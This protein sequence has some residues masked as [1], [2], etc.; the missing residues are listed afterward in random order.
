[1]TRMSQ[2]DGS[3]E[4]AKLIGSLHVLVKLTCYITRVNSCETGQEGLWE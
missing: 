4:P 1:M 3:V 2:R